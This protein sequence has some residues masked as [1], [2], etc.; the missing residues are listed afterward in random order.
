[1][2]MEGRKE[3]EVKTLRRSCASKRLNER[4]HRL[5][6]GTEETNEGLLVKKVPSEKTS[7]SWEGKSKGRR[8]FPFSGW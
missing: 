5:C 6:W 3:V 8:L 1:M 7:L 4:S 2:C